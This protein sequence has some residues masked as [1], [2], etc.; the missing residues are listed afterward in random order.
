[1]RLFFIQN[2]GENRKEKV[3][4]IEYTYVFHRKLSTRLARLAWILHE[5][6]M[7]KGL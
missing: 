7:S 4:F 6:G 3:F 2:A 1:M 5:N